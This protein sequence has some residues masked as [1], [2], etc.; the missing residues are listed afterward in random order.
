MGSIKRTE[1]LKT[2]SI[3][4]FYKFDFILISHL[5]SIYF[6]ITSKCLAQKLIKGIIIL[7]YIFLDLSV[8][9]NDSKKIV[10]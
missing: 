5:I 8:I 7:E 2:N 4:A 1:Q 6:W 10:K 3:L 9:R